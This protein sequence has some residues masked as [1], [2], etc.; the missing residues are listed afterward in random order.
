MSGSDSPFG[1][2]QTLATVKAF[3]IANEVYTPMLIQYD[4]LR[5]SQSPSR[6]VFVSSVLS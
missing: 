4:L 3:H 1:A 2:S 5:E 6:D